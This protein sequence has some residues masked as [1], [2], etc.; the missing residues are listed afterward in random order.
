MKL[1]KFLQDNY[2]YNPDVKDVMQ[3]YI[4]QYNSWYK[5][6]VADFNNYFIYMTYIIFI[7]CKIFFFRNKAIYL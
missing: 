2:N 7:R 1:E 4:D 6:D 5:G 3:S